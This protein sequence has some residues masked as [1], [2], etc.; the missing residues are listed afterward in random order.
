LADAP[1]GPAWIA[2]AEWEPHER[3]WMAWPA[4]PYV[5][6]GG[7]A[8]FD[9]YARTARAIARHEPVT[10]LCRPEE[11]AEAEAA[12]GDGVEVVTAAIDD[13]WLRD[14]G[15]TFVRSPEGRLGAI[16]W[17]FNGWGQQRWA[18]WEHDQ[19]VSELVA[20]RAGAESVVS[21]LVNEGGGIALDGEGTVIVTASVQ[22]DPERNP[23]WARADV[24]AELARTLGATTVIWLE[25]GLCADMGRYGTRGHVDLMAAFVRPGVVV[26]HDQPDPDHPDAALT[27]QNQAILEQAVDGRGRRLELVPL[28]APTAPV[29]DGVPLDWSYVNFAFANG[30]IVLGAFGDPA[31]RE[32][33]ATFAALLPDRTIE[34]VPV[35]ALFDKGGGL[36]CIT[37]QQPVARLR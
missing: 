4:A 13:S 15:P 6:A 3:T 21:A 37:Q 30:A 35:A 22:L 29:V 11:R 7:P 36:H 16:E 25:R 1:A 31:D 28:R 19:H 18:R 33:V 26:V 10:M 20:E 34:V 5:R 17:R 9:A 12:V 23:G 27:A 14:S 2:P 24:E 8:I 32:A